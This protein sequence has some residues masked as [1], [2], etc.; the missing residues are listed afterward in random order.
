MP[1]VAQNSTTA[2][3]VGP[4]GPAPPGV[5]GSFPTLRMVMLLAPHGSGRS[6]LSVR[7]TRGNTS[8]RPTGALSTCVR[9]LD[10][11]VRTA[12]MVT[13]APTASKTRPRIHQIRSPTIAA[14]SA[15]LSSRWV[16]PPNQPGASRTEPPARRERNAERIRRWRRNPT[17]RM[18]APRPLTTRTLPVAVRLVVMRVR[19]AGLAF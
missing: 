15:G 1:S 11:M 18:R 16:G 9:D 3:I 17:R 4:L 8:R 12:K 13:P 6:R 2:R 19:A 10:P 14:L 7:R 5:G